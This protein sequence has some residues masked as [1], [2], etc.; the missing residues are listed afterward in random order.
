MILEEFLKEIKK[1]SVDIET[2]TKRNYY[3]HLD[4]LFKMIAYDGDRLDKKHS[5]MIGT[6]L[7][8]INNTKRNDFRDDLSKAE[9]EE[10]IESLKTDIDCM[11]FRMENPPGPLK[12]E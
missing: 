5:L 3:I 2:L 9:L 6:Y 8:Y 11:I 10:I 4:R 7:Q 12:E 1:E